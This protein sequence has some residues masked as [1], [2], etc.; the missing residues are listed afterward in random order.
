M[1][2]PVGNEHVQVG[3]GVEA[4]PCPLQHDD[5][6]HATAR[7]QVLAFICASRRV[8]VLSLDFNEAVVDVFQPVLLRR[9]ISR[10]IL[11]SRRLK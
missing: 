3:M 10:Q 5:P 9:M 7:R 6:T 8:H 11:S 4:A 2:R 1:P